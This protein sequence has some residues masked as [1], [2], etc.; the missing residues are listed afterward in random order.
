MLWSWKGLI[1]VVVDVFWGYKV[2]FLME[3][4]YLH[5]GAQLWHNTL[6]IIE[7]WPNTI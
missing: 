7:C 5:W 1:V 6:I 4:K 3:C 2:C